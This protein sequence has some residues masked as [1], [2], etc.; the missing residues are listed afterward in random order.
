MK[1]DIRFDILKLIAMAGVVFIHCV[2]YCNI[3]GELEYLSWKYFAVSVP[4]TVFFAMTNVFV[5]VS[6]HLLIKKYRTRTP[7][8]RMN[9]IIGMVILTS[10]YSTVIYLILVITGLA[11]FS[12][13][14]ALKSVF[15]VFVN[16]YWFVG[17][18][19]FL[20]FISPLLYKAL[21]I[22]SEKELRSLCLVNISVFSVFPSVFVFVS[23]LDFYDAGHGKSII[24]MILLFTCT[25][26]LD[27]FGTEFIK[28][29]RRSVLILVA[30]S[31]TLILVLSRVV[32]RYISYRI[33]LGGD[34]EAR[35]FFDSSVFITV[36]SFCIFILT[37]KSK[38]REKETAVR[39]FISLCSATTL[40]IYL[41]H[42]NP[43][44]RD[45]IWGNA[46]SFI[47]GSKNMEIVML[48]LAVTA[49][50][51]ASMA[52]E[53]TRVLISKKINSIKKR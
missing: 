43:Y 23:A 17:A 28:K 12:L 50:F 53:L 34:G 42:N 6:S 27:K 38:E 1:K 30:A 22:F 51:V 47:F 13:F 46:K 35:L 32:L 29:I 9:K 41:I 8:V 25:F 4:Y 18:Y 7:S 20:Y 40:G 31:S 3:L 21:D 33:N 2:G 49:V 10:V 44:L 36:I 16:Q 52:A 11:D 15:S 26:Y 14:A 19:L 37:L 24:W 45:V 48:I 39:R 5:I